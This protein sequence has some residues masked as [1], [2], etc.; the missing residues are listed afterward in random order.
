MFEF[1]DCD[2]IHLAGSLPD[3]SLIWLKGPHPFTW[4]MPERQFS[5]MFNILDTHMPAEANS[6]PF[7]TSERNRKKSVSVLNWVNR[8]KISL[9]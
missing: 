1:I 2:L 4:F 7:D 9:W 6:N 8:D 3:L 5:S